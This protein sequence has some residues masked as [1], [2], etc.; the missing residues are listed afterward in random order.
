MDE[1]MKSRS[2]NRV[3]LIEKSVSIFSEMEGC[4]PR[5]ENKVVS[6]GN[7]GRRMRIFFIFIFFLIYIAHW[8]PRKIIRAI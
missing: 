1:E 3:I 2:I 7:A 8:F 4:C 5:V 6:I